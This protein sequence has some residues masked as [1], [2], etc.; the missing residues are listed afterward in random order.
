MRVDILTIFPHLFRDFLTHG[1]VRRARELGRLEVRPTQLRAL[2]CDRHHAVDDRPYGGGPGMLLKPEPVCR[3]LD[4]LGVQEG[5][6]PPE[7]TQLVLL[8]PR[9]E[10]LSQAHLE[11]FAG[12]DRLIFLCGRY[13]GYDER[14]LDAY[15][16][17]HLSVGDYVL[18]GGEVPAMTVIEGVARL[19]PDVLG[20][21]ESARRDSFGEWAGESGGEGGLDHASWTRP[22]EYRGRTVPEILKSGDHGR[23]EAWRRERA[24]ERTAERHRER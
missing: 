14:I 11:E 24:R 7:G 22:P 6:E 10:R 12:L 9:G 1:M 2:T 15:P 5:T 18:S 8:C 20:D 17:R 3:A 4:V 16:W 19:L 13:E 21:A 23:I